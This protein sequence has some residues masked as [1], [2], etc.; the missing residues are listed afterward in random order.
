[1]N[2]IYSK[3]Y[4]EA[5]TITTP[6]NGQCIAYLEAHGPTIET[7]L[8]RVGIRVWCSLKGVVTMEKSCAAAVTRSYT[9]MM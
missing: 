1:M 6:N 2:I 5:T 4:L 9:G 8:Q 7:S 3:T